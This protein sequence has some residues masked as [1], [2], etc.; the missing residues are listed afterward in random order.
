M[1]VAAESLHTPCVSGNEAFNPWSGS[2]SQPHS[3]PD[4]DLRRRDAY[5]DFSTAV[6]MLL[7]VASLLSFKL[8]AFSVVMVTL[9]AVC[10]TY[11][12][13]AVTCVAHILV[14]GLARLQ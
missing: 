12:R 11:D 6:L 8:V 2:P 3:S 1:P 14:I 5:L 4:S 9:V 10:C 7:H 13:R